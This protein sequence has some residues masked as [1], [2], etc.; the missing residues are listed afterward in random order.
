MD[1]EWCPA[2]AMSA[3]EA[4]ASSSVVLALAAALAGSAVT[5]I[6]MRRNEDR[7][8]S[9]SS[10]CSCKCEIQSKY[11]YNKARRIDPQSKLDAIIS[12]QQNEN[13]VHHV[14]TQT[15]EDENCIGDTVT[16][17]MSCSASEL[18][19]NQSQESQSMPAKQLISRQSTLSEASSIPSDLYFEELFS[20]DED[21]NNSHSEVVDKLGS[22]KTVRLSIR[23][24]NSLLTDDDVSVDVDISNRR[25]SASDEPSLQHSSLRQRRRSSTLRQSNRTRNSVCDSMSTLD[26]EDPASYTIDATS[27]PLRQSNTFNEEFSYISET[28][29]RF[30]GEEDGIDTIMELATDYNSSMHLLR[31]SRAISALAH[32]LTA[33][34]DEFSCIEEAAKLLILLFGFKRVSYALGTGTDHFL[35]KR[36]EVVKRQKDRGINGSDSLSTS[37]Q[38]S[39][40]LKCLD[41][42][43]RRPYEGTCWILTALILHIKNLPLC[44]SY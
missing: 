24:R 3:M 43:S 39:F 32:R 10:C 6:A 9:I 30:K 26:D 14:A 25:S 5:A 31:R 7:R 17:Q 28:E 36:F 1:N 40:D 20:T 22:L 41:S 44:L 11:G 8:R 4:C 23:K 21:Y 29:R 35:L 38:L 27:S 2:S 13:V 34:P 16:T 18:C 15:L 42:D 33:A 37:T 19:V 12:A